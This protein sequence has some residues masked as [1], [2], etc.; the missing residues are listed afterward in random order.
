M[1]VQWW[2]ASLY[3]W[4]HPPILKQNES[5]AYH[6]KYTKNPP[7]GMLLKFEILLMAD[8]LEEKQHTFTQQIQRFLS[9]KT[10]TTS[11]TF[12]RPTMERGVMH[13]LV[14]FKELSAS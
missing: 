8:V 2:A 5:H 7:S 11:S 9:H 6:F 1:G 13:T 4:R 3:Y 14:V 12:S 10:Q